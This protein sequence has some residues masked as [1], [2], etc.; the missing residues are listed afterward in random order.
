MFLATSATLKR[1]TGQQK[2]KGTA[3][4]YKRLQLTRCQDVSHVSSVSEP[5][6]RNVRRLQVLMKK[7]FQPTVDYYTG[8]LLCGSL[9][10]TNEPPSRVGD[11]CWC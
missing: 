9:Y 7:R 1:K 2:R 10:T 8:P 11:L 5:L 3:L 6:K 4:T